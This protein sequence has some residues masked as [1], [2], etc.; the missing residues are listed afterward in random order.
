MGEEDDPHRPPA[1]AA[2]LQKP[3]KAGWA[4]TP[5]RIAANFVGVLLL[6]ALAVEMLIG[7]SRSSPQH[8]IVA[9]A[10]AW[11]PPSLFIILRQMKATR[12]RLLGA[13]WPA[14][15]LGFIAA[16][17]FGFTLGTFRA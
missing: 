7:L 1:A 10:L 9:T 13:F 11:L 15:G 2:D 17:V 5:G 4:P 12:S 6:W 14:L 16:L 3:K 8:A